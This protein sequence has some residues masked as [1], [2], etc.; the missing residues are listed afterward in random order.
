MFRFNNKRKKADPDYHELQIWCSDMWSVLWNLWKRDRKTKIIP[1]LD[2]TWASHSIDAWYRNAIYHDAGVVNNH[3]RE[4][5][6]GLYRV[7]KPPKDLDINPELAC[8]KYYELI[9]QIL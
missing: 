9:K 7:K 3:N 4:F 2:F 1:E 5:Q 8:Y 6:K